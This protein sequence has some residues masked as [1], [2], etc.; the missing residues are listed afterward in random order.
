VIRPEKLSDINLFFVVRRAPQMRSEL[1]NR[2]SLLNSK[3]ALR[4]TIRTA[5]ASRQQQ[6]YNAPWRSFDFDSTIANRL[7]SGC[8]AA[9]RGQSKPLVHALPIKFA[10]SYF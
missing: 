9:T 3:N 10:L 5:T 6:M 7:S 1:S 8:R 4:Q 2:R